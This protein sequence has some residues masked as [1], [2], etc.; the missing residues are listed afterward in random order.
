MRLDDQI[1]LNPQFLGF[2]QGQEKV[3]DP[4]QSLTPHT[5]IDCLASDIVLASIQSNQDIKNLSD[6]V[7]KRCGREPFPSISVMETAL[8]KRFVSALKMYEIVVR[9]CQEVD[10]IRK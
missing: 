2:L 5:D 10:S 8:K 6:V 3:N 9:E 4:V 1:C 7:R